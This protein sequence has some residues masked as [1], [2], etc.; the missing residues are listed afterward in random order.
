MAT[1]QQ[2]NTFPLFF[3]LERVDNGYI[4]KS[5][6]ETAGLT[7]EA[8]WRK[9]VV[10]DDKIDQR[11]GH[12]LH[13]DTMKKELPITFFVEAVTE[14]TYKFE[15]D[16]GI[17]QDDLLQAK[18]LFYQFHL[19]N[20]KD[21]VVLGLQVGETIEIYGSNAE[22]LAISN[23]DFLIRVGGVHMMR[24]PNNRDGKKQISTLRP[25]VTLLSATEEQI[26]NWY[27]THRLDSKTV[28]KL[29]K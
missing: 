29:G 9:E 2:T 10:L 17:K 12:L 6:E 5:K 24:F 11:I 15:G 7:H 14:N 23:P 16:D 1:N 21:D 3:T 28:Q 4:L 19:K 22:K 27:N 13:L 18:L 20:Y 8:Q 26:V 25:Q